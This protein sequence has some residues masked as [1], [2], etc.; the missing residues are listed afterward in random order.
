MR[1]CRI[2]LAALFPILA[3]G[4][5]TA[6]DFGYPSGEFAFYHATHTFAA[7]LHSGFTLTKLLVNGVEVRDF[8]ATGLDDAAV[9]QP[10]YQ[11]RYPRYGKAVPAEVDL[12]IQVRCHWVP[13]QEYVLRVEGESAS[14][15][16]VVLQAAGTPRHGPGY[17]DLD[18]PHCAAVVLRESAGIERVQEPV[19]VK[20]ALYSDRLTDPVREIRV[21]ALDEQ[22]SPALYREVPSQ[23][24][25]LSTWDD[26]DLVNEE[27]RD[28]ASGQRIVRYLPTTTFEVAFLADVSAYGQAVY[29]V[30]YGNPAAA[31]PVYETDLRVSGPEIGQTISNELTE[32]DLDDVSGAIFQI[33]LKQG[34]DTV[35]EHKLETNGAVHWNPGAYS[36]PHSWVHASDW[37]RVEFEQVTGPVFHMTRRWAP[38]PH[39]DQV[40]VTITY[41]FYAGKPYLVSSSLTEVL[42]EFHGKALRNGEIVFN[43]EALNTFAYRDLSGA[44]HEIPIATTLKHPEHAV[45]IPYNV[46]WVAFANPATGIGFGAV[47]LE[48]ANTNR[49]GGLTD[50]EQPYY[51]V[52]NGPWIYFSRALNYSFGSNNTSRMI[53][54]AAGSMYYE[55]TAFAP[56]VLE[57]GDEPSTRYAPLDELHST[58]RHPLHVSYHL[59]TDNRNNTGWVVPILVEPFDEGVEGAVGGSQE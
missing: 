35:L 16:S 58:M 12:E 30:F 23:V 25:H 43:H 14:G 52:A 29:L 6:V 24:Y 39:M 27:E 26:A 47:G 57:S 49:Y 18:W 54:C 36:P 19:H 21:V 41:V 42:E 4:A 13:G 40:R 5:A 20:M 2:T 55:K 9:K 45:D 37:Q 50:A 7:G 1:R 56:F 46:P 48:L 44:V 22:G 10:G 11:R 28:E 53:R 33:S 59:D 51:Y 38:L 15:D 34:R 17:W 8:E 31:G 3:A 32:I